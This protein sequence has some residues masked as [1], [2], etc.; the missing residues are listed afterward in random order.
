M[1]KFWEND[2]L[3]SSVGAIGLAIDEA[4][5]TIEADEGLD[6][7]VESPDHDDDFFSGMSKIPELFVR[8][9]QETGGLVKRTGFF[10]ALF[11]VVEEEHFEDF[12]PDLSEHERQLLAEYKMKES[13]A[14]VTEDELKG[15]GSKQPLQ[16]IKVL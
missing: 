6:V 11:L 8:E 3:S 16:G 4:T 5:A 9:Q 1:D 14:A 10:K 13:M 7:L 15:R 12:G 2:T